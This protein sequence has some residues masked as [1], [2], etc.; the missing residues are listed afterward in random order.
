MEKENNIEHTKVWKNK[1]D[2]DFAHE[3]YYVE[4]FILNERK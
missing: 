1:A 2:Y 3:Y 4:E